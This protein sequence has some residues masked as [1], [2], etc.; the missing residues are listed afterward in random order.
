MIE[1]VKQTIKKYN[2]L[3]DND[4]V[5]VGLSGGAD[6]V[7]LLYML[8]ELV[9]IKNVF[10]MHVNHNL[11]GGDA[12]ADENFTKELCEKLGIP[13]KIFSEDV[14]EFAKKEGF[15]IEEAGR[16]IR[17]KRME[18]AR[19][20]FNATKIA[21]GHHSDDVVETVLMNLCRGA[22]LKGLCGIPPIQKNI[23]RP[24]IDVSRKEIE[25]FLHKKQIPYITDKSNLSLDY[26]RNRIRQ[27]I[28]PALEKEVN[29]NAS[30]NIARNAKLIREEDELL[31]KLALD[32]YI[33]CRDVLTGKLLINKL[34][35]L[36]DVLLRRVIR[37]VISKVNKKADI[38]MVH[39]EAVIELLHSKTGKEIHLP[40]LIVYKTNNCIIFSPIS[41]NTITK[42]EKYCYKIPINSWVYVQEIGATVFFSLNKPVNSPNTQNTNIYCTNAFNYDKVGE[43][44]YFRTRRP[45]DKITFGGTVPFTKKIKDYF[46]DN[47][48][49]RIERD[50][51]PL[52]AIDCEILWILDKHNRTNVN[53][54]PHGLKQCWISLWR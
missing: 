31:A 16:N 42:Q 53:Y 20:F 1:I 28:I 6:S 50:F 5:V 17:Y 52:C 4:S 23:V 7:F 34:F 10:A 39:I 19:I 46:I 11:R 3:D 15:G 2:M 32:A 49:P 13:L 30:K 9:E 54:Q 40:R 36:P 38:N 35:D 24:L 47:K 12:N 51:I 45:G 41:S 27:I 33:E 29:L 44:I 25:E 37:L 26:T 18:E 48:L 21:T 14:K 43:Y 22:G 8:L